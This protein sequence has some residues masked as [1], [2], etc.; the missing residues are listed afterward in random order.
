ML[1][2]CSIFFTDYS[3]GP[4]DLAPVLDERGF[5]S[6]WL[7]E[8]SHIPLPGRSQWPGGGELPKQ[9]Y[10]VFDPFVS[11]GAAAAATKNLKLGTGVCLVVQRDPIQVAKEV[12]TLDQISGGRFL[13]GVGGGWNAEEMADHGTDPS[14]RFKL[15]RERIEAMKTIWT[16]N[17]PQYEGEFVRFGEMMTWPKP[18]QKPHPPIHVGGAFPGGARRAIAYGDGWIPVGSREPIL[19]VLPEFRRMAQEKGRDPDSIEISLYGVR[20]DPDDVARWRDAGIHR[21]V[22][23]LPSKDADEV[24]PLVDS[25]AELAE[26]FA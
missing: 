1:F 16:E 26:R 4:A 24:L 19:E 25:L 11:L 12:A 13:F 23:G 20:G 6:L 21:V 15:M 18:V 7:A 3:I 10:D 17:K 22:F 14:R 9:Y 2:G 5:E 8:H